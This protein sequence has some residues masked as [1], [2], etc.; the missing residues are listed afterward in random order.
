MKIYL[1]QRL[2][3]IRNL[4]KT[5]LG[6]HYADIVLLT[7]AILS[8]CAAYRWPG[9]GFDEKRFV[10]LLV[11]YS[12]NS[13]HTS[14][15]CVPE[16]I[17]KGLINESETS[18]FNN[19]TRIFTDEEIDLDIEEASSKYPNVKREQ[20]R[21]NSY[22]SIIYTWLRCGYSHEYL[23]KGNAIQVKV[24]KRK[25]RLS[26]IGRGMSETET[27]RMVFV[28]IDYLTALAE[29]HISILNEQNIRHPRS[30]WI[31]NG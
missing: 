30:W 1:S 18:Y 5:D 26:Y 3:F 10:E 6:V 12:L 9:K 7:S 15:I 19:N 2:Q 22:A 24:S 17:N 11:K 20:L 23:P 4:L 28:H 16:L 29:H 25:A 21:K 31:Q 8:A 13:H 27:K 14:W